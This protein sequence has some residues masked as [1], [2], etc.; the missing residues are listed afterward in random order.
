MD[1]I[2]TIDET[3]KNTTFDESRSY[4]VRYAYHYLLLDSDIY[5]IWSSYPQRGL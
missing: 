5:K 1:N 3:S 4:A 2:N